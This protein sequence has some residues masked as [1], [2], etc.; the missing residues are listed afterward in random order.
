MEVISTITADENAIL[1][2]YHLGSVMHNHKYPSLVSYAWDDVICRTSRRGY[3]P[4]I[5]EQA[6][7]PAEA[8]GVSR[9]MVDEG[10][11]IPKQ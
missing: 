9:S 5:V 4:A 11:S 8:S 10:A 3:D 6:T 7:G 1:S 2:L